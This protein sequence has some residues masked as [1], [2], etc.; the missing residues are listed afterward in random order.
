MKL[1]T[2]VLIGAGDR[3]RAYA[4]YALNNPDRLKIIGVADP[5]EASRNEVMKKHGIPETMCFSTWEE[6]FERKK[7]ADAVMICTQDK[8][9]YGPSMKSIET[10]YDILL[11]KPIA[12][13]REEC[14][15]LAGAAEVK[16]VK[17]AVCLVL[18]YSKFFMEIK[19]IIDSGLVG[20]IVS[21]VH[22]GN[23]GFMH[24]AHSFVRGNWRSSEDSS[25]VILQNACHDIDIIQWLIGK[26]CLR[27][28][29]FGSLIYFNK[30]N[31]PPGAPLRCT[32]NCM[33]DCPFDA[34]KWYSQ[35]TSEIYRGWF[36]SAAVGCPN[37]SDD[38]VKAALE[39]GPF[40]RCVFQCD[41]DVVDHQ[42]VN[43]EFEGGATA[44]F[45]LCAFTPVISR[46][47]KVMGTKGQIRGSMEENSID[48]TSFLTLKEHRIDT[49]TNEKSKTELVDSNKGIIDAF[50]EYVNGVYSCGSLPDIRTSA[51]SHM[52]C[53]AAEESRLNNGKIVEPYAV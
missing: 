35:D 37:P 9:H 22:N 31:C 4:N 20:K 51:D 34:N 21:I 47:I 24:Y 25:P 23:V 8:I 50:C 5:S 19:K 49:K 41:N 10:G 13:T 48:V 14:F 43:M 12:P 1:V 6:V 3:G 11:E 33:Y 40:G 2:A 28:S 29:S 26:K 39:T 46:T 38:Q 32:D 45:S 15:A 18:R 16:G 30:D 53:F 44:V 7:F 42:I 36:R 27:V 17:F 52:I